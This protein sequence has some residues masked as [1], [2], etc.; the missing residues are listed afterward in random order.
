MSTL[1]IY[2]LNDFHILHTAVLIILVM[3]YI[4]FLVIIFLIISGNFY[5]VTTFSQLPSHL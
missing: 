2:P 4:K 1:R 3:L 5:L